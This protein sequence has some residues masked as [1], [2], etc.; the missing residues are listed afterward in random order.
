[1]FKKAG[2]IIGSCILGFSLG[3]A[4]VFLMQPSQVELS[5]ENIG[6]GLTDFEKQALESR[7]LSESELK[8]I[9]KKHAYK[10]N[11]VSGHY[12]AGR[13]AQRHHDWKEAGRHI[14][15][16]LNKTGYNDQALLKRAMVLAMG[17]GEFDRAFELAHELRAQAQAEQNSAYGALTSLFIAI[18]QFK[19][20]DYEQAS[21][22]IHEM[23]AGSLSNFILPL[24]ESWADAAVG[25]HKTAGLSQSAIHI[26]HAI[27][28]ADFMNQ[29]DH[30]ENLLRQAIRVAN[31][32]PTDVERIADIYAHIG[33]TQQAR[34]LYE[35]A[36]DAV[37]ENTKL[38]EKIEMLDSGKPQKIFERVQSAEHGVA[39]ALYDMAQILAQEYSDE[40][41]RVFAHMAIYLNPD[42]TD[43]KFL[44]A[45]LASRNEQR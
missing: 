4:V 21:K 25:E 1:M 17:A 29:H 5:S 16:V 31:L 26:Y 19:K 38:T 40:S 15:E 33:N 23:P 30:I 45:K 12:L 36:L 13:F 14:G 42:L 44:L 22:S 10:R 27:M 35:Q 24:L 39:H 18:E 34:A 6:I 2:I 28:I 43:A 8:N 37:G 20:R 3:T 9:L 7:G 32:S 11:T 41:A